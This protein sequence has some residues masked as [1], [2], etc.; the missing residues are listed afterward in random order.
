MNFYLSAV[1]SQLQ[2]MDDAPTIG[3]ILCKQSNEVIVGSQANGS[4]QLRTG[5]SAPCSSPERA[6]HTSG[7]GKGLAIPESCQSTYR[8][9]KGSTVRDVRPWHWRRRALPDLL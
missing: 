6:S 9:R 2:H 7:V 4:R 5:R 8:H 1:D 3:I